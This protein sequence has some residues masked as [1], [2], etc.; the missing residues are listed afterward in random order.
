MQLDRMRTHYLMIAKLSSRYIVL[1]TLK[2]AANILL[3]A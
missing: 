2:K 1:K 3:T